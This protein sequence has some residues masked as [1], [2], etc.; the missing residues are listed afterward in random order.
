MIIAL[1]GPSG[2]GKSTVGKE[3][4][5]IM[6]INYLDTGAMYRAVAYLKMKR[7]IRDDDEEKLVHAL[8]NATFEFKF[9]NLKTTVILDGLDISAELR[10]PAI[11]QEA[12]RLSALSPV[13]RI[14]VTM[15]RHICAQGDFVVEGRDIGSVV[16]P[17]TPYKFYL[18][19]SVQE[20]VQRR[21]QQLEKQGVQSDLDYIT[22]EIE[23]RDHR[24]THRYDSPLRRMDDA[25]YLDSTDLS[26]PEV[27]S[28]LVNAVET[29]MKKNSI[30]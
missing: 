10:D 18:D 7:K 29:K 28:I 25:M 12:S 3:L 1:D 23:I 11:S 26:L 19:A 6:G 16:F 30:I 15:Q 21:H 17:D 2:A 24:D 5:Q 27:V 22:R 20:R 13:R 14:M 4:A 8:E 9:E